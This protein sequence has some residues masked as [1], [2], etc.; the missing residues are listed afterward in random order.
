MPTLVLARHAKA[1]PASRDDH[2]RRLTP[3][4]RAQAVALGDW[5]RAQGVAPDRVLV[6]TAA[7]A[8]ETWESAGTGGEVVVAGEVYE[9]SADYL[10]ALV[11]STGDD[12]GTLVVVGH[13]PA[14]ERLAWELDDGPEAREITDRGLPPAGVVVVQ[15]DAWD[16][17]YGR[18][19]VSRTSP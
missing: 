11:G 3:G 6:S 17:P 15:L 14:L 8:R 13:N 7:R 5:L 4:G 1:E 18:L 9:A 2:A 10:R 16:A 12:V 19:V